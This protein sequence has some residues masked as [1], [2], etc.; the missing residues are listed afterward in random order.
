MKKWSRWLALALASALALSGCGNSGT[1]EKPGT[2]PEKEPTTAENQTQPQKEES[3]DAS[4]KHEIKDLVTS[5]LVV[6]EME[7]FNMLYSQSQKEFDVLCNNWDGLLEVD[8]HGVPIAGIAEDWGTEDGGLTWTFHIRDGVKWVDVNAEEKAD[9]NAW[10]FASGLEWVLNFHKNDS[11]NTS[12]P[13]EMIKGANEY[14]EYTKTLSQEEAYALTAGEGSKFLEMVGIEIPD[15]HTVIYH[16]IDPKPYFDSVATYSCL[17]PISQAMVDELG[18]PDGVR[19]MNNETMWYNGPYL[20]TTYIQGNEKVQTKNPK[21]WD[22][23]CNLFDTATIKM[24]ESNDVA[25]QLYQAGELD[26][27]GLNESNLTTIYNSDSNAYH[28]YLVEKLPTKYSWQLH[29]NFAKNKEDGTPDTNWNLA[30]ANEAFRLS[31]YYGLDLGQ[32]YPRINAINPMSCENNCYTMKGLVYTSDGT[33][34]TDLVKQ[35]LGIQE[36]GE[37]LARLNKE[38]AQQYKEQAMQ[39]LSALGVTF[40]ISADYY[41]SAS[42]QTALDSAN[43]LKQVFSDSL[44]DDYVKLNIKTYVSSS[45]Q[46]VYTPRL[47]S[48]VQTGWGADYGDPQNYLGQMTY[49][50]E[51]AYFPNSYNYVNEV[52]V[53]ENTQAL[54]DVFKTLTDMVNE[55]DQIHDDLDARYKAY[56]KAEA[57]LIEHAIVV[58]TYYDVGWCLSKIN[59][60]TQRNAMF[61]CQNGKMKGWETSADGYTTEEMT[62]LKDAFLAE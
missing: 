22:T 10:D 21:Y 42:N 39:E 23:E 49:G 48:I 24:V 55:A 33:D 2:E 30:V 7:T 51:T 29:F 53:N 35:E 44:G 28:D 62:A 5:Q 54:I 18:G 13:L 57:Y 8:P 50:N 34:Y 41:I 1:E 4:G 3:K 59:L 14:Y 15:D 52:E 12:M 37:T 58:P 26:Y 45:R 25:F 27:V 31:W 36:N 56:A 20:M 6:N 16:C 9:C 19:A 61:G 40:P 32:Y 38:K 17:F 43:V 11:A 60:Y 46:E 47:H